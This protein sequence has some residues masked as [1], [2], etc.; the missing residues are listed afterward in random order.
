MLGTVLGGIIMLE[1]FLLSPMYLDLLKI[2]S[3]SNLMGEGLQRLCTK[4][5][6]DKLE[7]NLYSSFFIE[8][9]TLRT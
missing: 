7:S 4:Q 3:I 9:L 5:T 8:V 2:L 1:L 6:R